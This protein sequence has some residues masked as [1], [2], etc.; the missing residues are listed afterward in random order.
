M[1]W[2]QVEHFHA[3]QNTSSAS[4]QTPWLFFYI[5]DTFLARLGFVSP[6]LWRLIKTLWYK[7]NAISSLM[8]FLYARPGAWFQV[9][10]NVD[11]CHGL[12]CYSVWP[13][14]CVSQEVVF[15]CKLCDNHTMYIDEYYVQ[16][17]ILCTK[18]NTIL[19]TKMNTVTVNEP[20]ITRWQSII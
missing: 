4:I 15:P 16:S 11:Y 17:W 8:S 18:L 19:C 13:I 6:S 2:S 10:R 9:L 20:L 14:C 12:W 5:Y 7:P 3:A 1:A